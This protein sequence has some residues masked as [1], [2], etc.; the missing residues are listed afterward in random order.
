MKYSGWVAISE[1]KP[2]CGTGSS[3]LLDGM[4][5]NSV[6]SEIQLCEELD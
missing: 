3:S 4:A 2:L 6:L 1:M 5:L